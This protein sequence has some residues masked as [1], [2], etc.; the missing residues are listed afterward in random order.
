MKLVFK[1][2]KHPTPAIPSIK[3]SIRVV[4]RKLV[5]KKTVKQDP[6]DVCEN[7]SAYTAQDFRRDGDIYDFSPRK[8][9]EIWQ[10][11]FK[12]KPSNFPNTT[13]AN[14]FWMY[15]QISY[16]LSRQ[17]ALKNKQ[18][19][20]PAFKEQYRATFAKNLDGLDE[21]GKWLYGY[22]KTKKEDSP[23]AVKTKKVAA[24][25]KAV[26]VKKQNS[27]GIK[28]KMTTR[29][30]WYKILS[31]NFTKKLTDKQLGDLCK[32]EFPDLKLK[33]FDKINDVR[34][35]LY[36]K[37]LIGEIKEASV[38]YGED[39]KPLTKGKGP[40]V[41][42]VAKPAAKETKK[43]AVPAKAK[44]A[45]ATATKVA[46]SKKASPAAETTVEEL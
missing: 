29:Q 17:E 44:A 20:H 35:N 3:P 5:L 46:K 33:T 34:V 10:T 27:L 18:T 41:K 15:Q 12:D 37:G 31:Q 45:P 14:Y 30:F 28:T 24:I 13:G 43:I 23:M 16:E 8:L 11:L 22:L 38:A 9:T 7:F 32:A 19:L 4:G 39:R 21:F 26:E 2:L 25:K 40:K 42:A 6:L 1:K 36:N